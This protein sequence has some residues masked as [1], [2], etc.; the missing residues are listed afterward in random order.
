MI[1]IVLRT[2]GKDFGFMAVDG[3]ENDVFFHERDLLGLTIVELK[4]GEK[5]SISRVED[6]INGK[7]KCARNVKLA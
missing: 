7:G 2:N 1:G 4:R 3:Y 5:L 6:N